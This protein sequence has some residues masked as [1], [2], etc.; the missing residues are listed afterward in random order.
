[1]SEIFD[2]Q[3]FLIRSQSADFPDEPSVVYNPDLINED[4][5]SSLQSVSLFSR[6]DP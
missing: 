4:L 5:R 1:M 6:I 2:E 3:D